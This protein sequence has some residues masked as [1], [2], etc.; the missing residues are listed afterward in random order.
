V[1]AVEEARPGARPG[2]L[3]VIDTATRR[4][5]VALGDAGGLLAVSVREVGHRP[6]SHLVGQLAETLERAGRDLDAIGAVAVGTGPGSFTGLRVGLAAAKT[7]AWV[8]GLVLVGVG[9]TDALARA[10]ATASPGRSGVTV[11]LP[12]GARDHYVARPGSEPRLVPPGELA[13]ALDA[14]TPVAAVDLP[15]EVL[16]EAANGLGRAALDGLPAALLDLALERLAAGAHDDPVTLVPRYV[17]LP[18][19]I[20]PG[21]QE[22][23]WSPALR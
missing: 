13:S 1:T 12:A 18:R 4:S 7:L 20:A 6:G 9:S 2:P 14:G 19:G 21:T 15:L 3:L 22:A 23:A 11:V 17:A 10:A 16:G 8:R 5:V